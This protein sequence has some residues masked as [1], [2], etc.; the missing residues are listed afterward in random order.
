MDDA[1]DYVSWLS[2]ETGQHYRLL[3]EGGMGICGSRRFSDKVQ[4]GQ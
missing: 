1:Q 2:L 3:S 4:L